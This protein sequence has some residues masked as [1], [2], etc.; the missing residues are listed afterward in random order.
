MS[1]R[2]PRTAVRGVAGLFAIRNEA[3]A[4]LFYVGAVDIFGVLCNDSVAAGHLRVGV[5][6]AGKLNIHRTVDVHIQRLRQKLDISDRIQT[7]YKMGYRF[8][9]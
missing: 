6:I 9:I 5:G 7:V 4:V 1:K 2:T 3:H 8:E